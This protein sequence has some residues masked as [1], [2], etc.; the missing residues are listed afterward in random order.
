MQMPRGLRWMAILIVVIPILAACG[1]SDTDDENPTQEATAAANDVAEA[2]DVPVNTPDR[3]SEPA[4]IDGDFRDDPPTLF[5]ATGRPQL[6]EFFAFWCTI[7]NRIKPSIH[8]LEA[9]YWEQVDFVYLDREADANSDLVERFAIRGQPVLILVAPDGNEIKRW[10][11]EVD[12]NELR[13]AFDTYLAENE[14]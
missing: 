13:T 12:T 14:T 5:A 4:A 7:C 9:E 11:G 2:N 6:V 1:S 3:P 8:A 10:F